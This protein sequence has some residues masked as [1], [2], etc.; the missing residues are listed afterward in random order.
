MTARDSAIVF[1][2]AAI[3]IEDE[4]ARRPKGEPLP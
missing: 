4:C 1:S 3:R 2:F